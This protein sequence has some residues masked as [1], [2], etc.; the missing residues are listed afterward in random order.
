MEPE[1][2]EQ[3]M[4]HSEYFLTPAGK[5]GWLDA[6]G[7]RVVGYHIKSPRR[8]HLTMTDRV[9]TEECVSV[10]ENLNISQILH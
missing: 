7:K 3:E 1:K 6:Q 9:L 10:L 4:G 8:L 5:N 2:C